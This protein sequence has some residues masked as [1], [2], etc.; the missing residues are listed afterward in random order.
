MVETPLKLTCVPLSLSGFKRIIPLLQ[1]AYPNVD[2]PA[3][4]LS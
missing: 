2:P 3:K 1:S 4:L